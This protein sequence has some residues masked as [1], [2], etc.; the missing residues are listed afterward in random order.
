VPRFARDLSLFDALLRFERLP[1]TLL[2]GR[3]VPFLGLALLPRE[4][5]PPLLLGPLGFFSLLPLC[6]LLLEAVH[7]T[8]IKGCD[9]TLI[10][11]VIVAAWGLM[12]RS[13]RVAASAI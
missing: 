13:T 2:G 6:V 11:R 1:V 12:V 10:V 7:V 5:I 8:S 3:L 4:G 9:D